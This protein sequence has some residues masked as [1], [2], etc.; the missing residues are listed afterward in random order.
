MAA[1]S[2]RTGGVTPLTTPSPSISSPCQV[3]APEATQRRGCSSQQERRS[4][5]T[6]H[7]LSLSSPPNTRG[8][9]GGLNPLFW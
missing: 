1:H 9:G 4:P 7:P 5:R 8:S 3:C 2:T 6:H